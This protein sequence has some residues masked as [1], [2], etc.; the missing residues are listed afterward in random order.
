MTAADIDHSVMQVYQNEAVSSRSYFPSASAIAAAAHGAAFVGTTHHMRWQ[1][2]HMHSHWAPV[3]QIDRTQSPALLP[4]Q[5]L[6]GLDETFSYVHAYTIGLRV[7]RCTSCTV[8]VMQAN[9]LSAT[10]LM[11]SMQRKE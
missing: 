7:T 11:Q 2:I 4:S 9:R 5:M 10:E 3:A 1:D 8:N 6:V